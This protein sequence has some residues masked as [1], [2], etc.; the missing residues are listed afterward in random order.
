M[1]K[2]VTFRYPL[3]CTPSQKDWLFVASF[4]SRRGLPLPPRKRYAGRWSF[5]V[6]E[7]D[8]ATILA[9]CREISVAHGVAPYNPPEL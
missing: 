4:S 8:F 9:Y 7:D 6:R 5:Q 3:P 2:T 1:M